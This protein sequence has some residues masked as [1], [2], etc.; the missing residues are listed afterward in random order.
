MHECPRQMYPCLLHKSLSFVLIAMGCALLARRV[1]CT[2]QPCASYCRRTPPPL[3]ASFCSFIRRSYAMS[4][5]EAAVG[6]VAG[7]AGLLSTGIQLQESARKVKDFCSRMKHADERLDQLR[8]DL[9]T[10][11]LLMQQLQVRWQSARHHSELF[12]RCITSC[13][14]SAMEIEAAANRITTQMEQSIRVGRFAWARKE[15][16]I[17]KL[18]ARLERAKSSL[19][20]A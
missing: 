7:G 18:W 14:R 13:Q 16:N 2:A 1:A 19:Q 17:E 11:V 8:F 6:L 12:A 20:L 15:Q 9:D 4:G 3:W 5:V 10:T